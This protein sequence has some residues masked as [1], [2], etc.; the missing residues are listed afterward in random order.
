L[1][2]NAGRDRNYGFFS[3]VS[4]KTLDTHMSIEF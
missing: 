2:W 1:A 4:D 3:T